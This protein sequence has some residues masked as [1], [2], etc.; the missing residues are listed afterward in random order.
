MNYFAEPP[1]KQTK[2]AGDQYTGSYFDFMVNKLSPKRVLDLF[3]LT[4]FGEN[5]PTDKTQKYYTS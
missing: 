5:D 1:K 4:D 3:L 2:G